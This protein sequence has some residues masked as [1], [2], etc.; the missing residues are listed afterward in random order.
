MNT[1]IFISY[2]HDEFTE[3]VKIIMTSLSK[4]KEYQLW[5]DGNINA[6]TT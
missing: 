1:R 4:R 6:T 3:K 5:W 2:G